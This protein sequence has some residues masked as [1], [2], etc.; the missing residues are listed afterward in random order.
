VGPKAG[1][2][3][4]ETIKIYCPCQKILSVVHPEAYAVKI[5]SGE[6]YK[7]NGTRQRKTEASARSVLAWRM[8]I[9]VS[10]LVY[11]HVFTFAFNT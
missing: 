3:A 6:V 2:S 8:L 9:S 7:T 1:L 11:R 10:V 4:L 5:C